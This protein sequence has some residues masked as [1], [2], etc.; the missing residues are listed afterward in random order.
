[1]TLPR[2]AAEAL[3]AHVD[4]TYGGLGG[5]PKFPQTSALQLFLR[6]HRAGAHPGL[7]DAVLLACD[8]MAR[9][10]IYDQI[11]GGFHRYSVD[12]RWLVPHF[13]K[14]LYDNAQIPRVYLEAYQLTG[15]T[16]LRRI[17]EETLDY[18]LRDM[19]HPDGAFYSA[20]DADSEGEEGKYFVWTRAEVARLV[21]PADVELVCR[22]WDVSDE[23]NFEGKSILHVTLDVEQ[24]AKLFGRTPADAAAA[25]ARAREPL[26]AARSERVPPLRDEKIL[27]SWNALMIGTLAEA[28]RVLGAPRFV[29]AAARAAEF[30]WTRMRVDGRLFHTWAGD[31][32]KHGAYLDDHA[33]LADALVDLYEAT[34]DRGH[35]VRAR[36]LAAVLEARFHDATGGGYFFTA[37]DAEQLIARS[38]PSADG[39][40]P[41]GSAVAARVLLR[42]HH[43]TGDEAARARAEEVLRLYHDEATRNPFGYATYLQAL[44][45]Y[46]EGP[47]EVVVLGRRGTPD[48]ERLWTEVA[49]VYLPHRALVSAE[50]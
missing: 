13:E 8:H 24:V 45:L 42:L 39:S 23:G 29:E 14:M 32:A 49:G 15:R 47:A 25:I 43:L 17:V 33:F 10:G 40:L 28:G 34:G 18:V 7:L 44:E 12:A 4:H 50:P 20:T 5:A 30:I 1:P 37:H 21:D 27:T 3:L 11:G 48:V 41:S 16:D 22:Y 38:K 31:Q 19:R 35:L 6:Q 2:R 26:L 46:L 9:G 36:E